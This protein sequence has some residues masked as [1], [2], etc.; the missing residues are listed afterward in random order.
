MHQRQNTSLFAVVVMAAFGLAIAAGQTQD[1][2]GDGLLKGPFAFRHVAVQNI[3]GNFDP[4]EITASYGT[5]TFDG[6]GNYTIAGMSVDNTVASG[7]PQAL[8]VTGTY[9]IGANGAGYVA[10]PLYPTDYNKYVYGA[11]SQGVYS[12]SSTEAGQEG[13]IMNDIFVAIPLGSAPTNASF[14]STYQ[15]GVLD[16]TGGGAT[17]IMNALFG[18][19]PNGKGGFGN[20]TLNGQASNQLTTTVTQS[21]TGA[22]YNFNG[23]GSAT[24]T[25]PLPSGVSAGNAMFTGTKTIY[26]SA[27]GNFIL[28]WTASGYD[29]FFGVKAL[30]ITGTN[31]L[32]Q[33]LY[34]TT[35]LEDSSGISGTDSYYGGISDSGD[36]AGDGVVHERLNFP[37]QPS[38]DF[39]TDD[40]IVVNSDGTTG[41]DLNGYQYIFGDGGMAFV[42]IGTQGNFSLIVGLHAASF[43]GPGVYLNPIGVANAASYQPITASLAPGELITLVG[44][45]LSTSTMTTQGGQAFATSLGGVSVSIDGIPCPIYYV[46]PGQLSVIVPYAVASNQTGLANIQVT[47]N[48]VAS[49]IVQTYLTDAAPGAF[50]QQANGIGYAAAVHAA[51]GA[52]ITLSSPADPGEY[53]SL[54]LTGLGVV[55]PTVTDGTVGPINPLSVADLYDAGFLSVYF[56]DYGPNGSAG[57]PGTIEF[58]GLAPGLA[59]L[60]QINVQVPTSGLASGDNVYV[61]FSTDAAD[62]NQIQIP[63]GSAPVG[64]SVTAAHPH[65][66]ASRIQ[67]MRTRGSGP[68]THRVRR[69]VAV[70]Q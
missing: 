35:A 51:T 65:R 48:G 46:S 55:N 33:G 34:F 62:V 6:A 29:I 37:E 47:N 15:T 24:L 32:S 53:I 25:I 13:A 11:V 40:Q 31:S 56:N 43:S 59:G 61:E 38:F 52:L 2:S 42:G 1:I 22:S 19:S 16:F 49:N 64:R 18:L 30:T 28:G 50:S 36:S 21:I 20:I 68:A 60:Y 7:A 57:N 27:D 44:T 69:G 3:D 66:R 17:A 8:S 26:E 67:A 63:Y 23:D 41:V 54:F 5:I 58:A 4:S 39:G 14:S 9:A 12:G 70:A 10:N 45:G